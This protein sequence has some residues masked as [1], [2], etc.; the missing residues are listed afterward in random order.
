MLVDETLLA[1]RREYEMHGNGVKFEALK[2]CLVGEP[3]LSYDE[4]GA[5]LG[6][7]EGAVKAAVYR[8]RRRFRDLLREEIA[9]TVAD[10]ADVED[11]LHY[12]FSVVFS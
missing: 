2:E 5:R 12:L 6:M 4:I 10:P 9:D 3:S 1:L 7:T 8:M 11:E